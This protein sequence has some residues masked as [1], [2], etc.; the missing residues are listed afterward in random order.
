MST[1][2]VL[3]VDD[4]ENILNSLRR[5]LIDEDYECLFASNGKDALEII[6]NNSISVIVTDMRMPG[7]DGLT[8]LKEAKKISPNSTRIVLSGYTQLQQILATINQVDIFKFITKPWK[9]EE[10]FK[11]VI[12]QA[13]EY[14]N[15][16]M[17]SENLK[18]ALENRNAAYQNMLKNI[19]DRIASAK[20][21]SNLIK[22]TSKVIFEHL[23]KTID[24]NINHDKTNFNYDFERKFFEFYS[25]NI[26]SQIEELDVANLFDNLISSLIIYNK[27][28]KVEKDFIFKDNYKIKT[29]KIIFDSFI[30]YVLMANINS[31]DNYSMDIKGNIKYAVDN[32]IIEF[33]FTVSDLEN[34]KTLS[35]NNFSFVSTE[36]IDFI[37]TFMNEYLNMYNGAFKIKKIDNN[38]IIKIQLIK[39]EK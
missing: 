39:A 29:N 30:K 22:N 4:E 16:R 38:L 8:L 17:E 37:A 18:K 35:E 14:Y 25:E 31:N 5:G 3:F 23:F 11:V 7:M 34:E 32:E 15:L 21:E 19:E 1:G 20:N 27:Q 28:I 10:E 26:R 6:G 2:I 12:D 33:V 9:L 36:R 13:L 24:N